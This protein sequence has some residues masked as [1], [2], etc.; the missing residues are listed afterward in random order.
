MAPARPG[1]GARGRTRARNEMG[2][3][4]A[5]ITR[6]LATALR[7]RTPAPLTQLCASWSAGAAGRPATRAVLLHTPLGGAGLVGAVAGL[8]LGL[9]AGGAAVA[10]EGGHDEVT[11][12]ASFEGSGLLFRDVITVRHPPP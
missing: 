2:A 4:M 11:Q 1:A 10:A 6:L 5:R 8:G 12:V 7:T 9:A 3:P